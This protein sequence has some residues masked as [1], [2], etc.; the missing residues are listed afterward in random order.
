MQRAA[1]VDRGSSR[2]VVVSGDQHPCARAELGQ[3][4]RAKS[5]RSVNRAPAG[6]VVA[7][8]G[9]VQ[10][11]SRDP[12]GIGQRQDSIAVEFDSGIRRQSDGPAKDGT[13]AGGFTQR[14]FVG[15]RKANAAQG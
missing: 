10:V 8:N 12:G 15:S 4:A 11:G 3:G 6:R 5:D 9:Q 1:A 7:L 13:G 2:P 14:A